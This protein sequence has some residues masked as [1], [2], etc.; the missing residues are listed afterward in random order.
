M[1]QRNKN[2]CPS[3][4]VTFNFKWKG[5][6]TDSTVLN[7]GEAGDINVPCCAIVLTCDLIEP[8]ILKD[9]FHPERDVLRVVNSGKNFCQ[10]TFEVG[11]ALRKRIVKLKK[12]QCTCCE[13]TLTHDVTQEAA[14]ILVG[15]NF[16]PGGHLCN[17]IFL[18]INFL[19]QVLCYAC[20]LK[21]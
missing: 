21:K 15:K 7:T 2:Y 4:R 16:S 20:S 9:R 10:L 1:L 11:V 19:P 13:L 17:G 14:P 12:N 18:Q 8:Y 5:N 3:Y 6:L